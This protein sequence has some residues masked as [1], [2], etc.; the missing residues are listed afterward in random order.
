MVNT[1]YIPDARDIVWVDLNPTKGR[2]QAKRRPAI[3]VSARSYNKKTSLALLCPITSMQKG[4]PFEVLIKT[5]EIGGVV[6]S[7]HVR[8]LDWR[9]RKVKFITKA[10]AKVLEEVRDKLGLLVAG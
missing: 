2:E 3:V 9:A 7:D 1:A 4:Y 5:K 8:S 6:L 10:S